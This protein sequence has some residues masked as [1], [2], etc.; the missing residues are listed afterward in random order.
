MTDT[1]FLLDVNVL[2]ALTNPAH[3]QHLE[4]HAWLAEVDR[5]ATTPVT[6]IGLLRLLLNPAVVGQRVTGPAAL[7]LLRRLRSEDRWTFIADHTSLAATDIDLGGLAGHRQIV[8]FHL[9]GIA[10]ANAAVLATFD[11]RLQPCL[12]PDDRRF[13]H[14]I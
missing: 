7:A 10:A 11:R 9:V 6:E 13:V 4:A 12:A 2:V 5:F 1:V 8:D 3:A 14:V